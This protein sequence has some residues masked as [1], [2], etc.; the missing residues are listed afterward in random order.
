MF[1]RTETATSFSD[2][3]LL[4]FSAGF[5]VPIDRF[6]GLACSQPKSRLPIHLLPSFSILPLPLDH[7]NFYFT[8]Y[9]GCS[10]LRGKSKRKTGTTSRVLLSAIHDLDTH[11][12]QLVV[13]HFP[14]WLSIDTLACFNGWEWELIP[15]N[16]TSHVACLPPEIEDSLPRT[17]F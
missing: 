3:N 9:T 17:L 12:C 7:L 11:H 10:I 13:H 5:C 4:P 6:G 1:G 2:G 8:M 14:A 15:S 16:A